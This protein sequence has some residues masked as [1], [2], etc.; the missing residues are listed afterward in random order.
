MLFSGVAERW[1]I[2]ELFFFKENYK[3]SSDNGDMSN[4]KE[5][6]YNSSFEKKYYK[7]IL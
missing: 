1:V 2:I 7:S 5:V 3:N 4:E 6:L